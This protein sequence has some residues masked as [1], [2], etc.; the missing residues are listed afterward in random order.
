MQVRTGGMTC[1]TFKMALPTTL[2]LLDVVPP[3]TQ[4]QEL[5]QHARPVASHWIQLTPDHSDTLKVT[6]E[7]F[8]H[9]VH[10]TSRP[11]NACEHVKM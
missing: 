2:V 7:A 9:Q 6:M 10:T 8:K 4:G 5:N 1:E 3:H 11:K